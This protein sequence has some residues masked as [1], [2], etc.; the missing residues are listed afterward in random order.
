MIMI[1]A[2]AVSFS[3]AADAQFIVKIR[4][5]GPVYRARPSSPSPAHVWVGGNYVWRGGQYVYTDGYWAVPPGAGHRWV[6]G[7][8]KHRRGGWVWVPGHW[9]RFR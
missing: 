1:L 2:M 8:W 4:P 7:R 9:K 3:A 5:A 6:E